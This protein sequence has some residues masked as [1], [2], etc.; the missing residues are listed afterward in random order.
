MG[1]LREYEPMM[2]K[3]ASQLCE[4]LD[5]RRGKVID[6]NEWFGFFVFDG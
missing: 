1:A 2:L 5:E 3:R 4:Q 6:L